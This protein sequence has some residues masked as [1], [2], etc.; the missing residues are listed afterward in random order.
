MSYR[1]SFLLF[2]ISSSCLLHAQTSISGI[3]NNYAQVTAIDTC[4]QRISVD[5]TAS[6]G[7][8]DTLLLIQM[9]GADIITDNTSGFGSISNMNNAG[10]FEKVIVQ[11]VQGNDLILT[12][13]I[14]NNYD[15]DGRVQ[16]VN[17]PYYE[18]AVVVDVL[19]AKEWDGITG[20]ILA[21]SAETLVLEADIDVSGVGFR[22]GTQEL[23]YDGDCVWF[24]NYTNF[25]YDEQSIRAG[26]KGEGI[27]I[28]ENIFARG[29][30]AYTNG[31]G[32]G[33]D[34]N[35]GGG[36]GSHVTAGGQG[37]IN[38]NP[39]FFGCNGDHPGLGGWALGLDTSRL[40]LG[41]GGGAGHINN[42]SSVQKSDGGGIVLLDVGWLSANGNRIKANGDNADT[43]NGDGANGGGAGGTIMIRATAQDESTLFLEAKGGN[44][45]NANN[46]NSDQCHGPGGGGAG[47]LLLLS[48]ELLFSSNMSGGE[49]GLS[50]NSSSC[51]TG[52]NGA[53]EGSDGQIAII[54]TIPEREHPIMTPQIEVPN[55][56][57]DACTEDPA[58][59]IAHVE[60]GVFDLQWQLDSGNGFEN[61]QDGM[62]FQGVNTDSLLVL[63]PTVDHSY[64]LQVETDCDIFFSIP[65]SIALINSPV[66]SFDYNIDGLNTNFTNTS[67]NA[68]TFTWL[69]DSEGTSIEAN[70]TFEFPLAGFYEVTLIAENE[71]NSDTIVQQLQIGAPPVPV[72]GVEGLTSGCVPLQ[73]QFN[74]LSQGTYDSVEWTF[75]GG[76]PATSVEEQPVVIYEEAGIYNVQLS[77]FSDFPTAAI[78]ESQLIEVFPQPVASFTYIIDGLTV[79][80]VNISSD[81]DSYFWDFGDGNS[82]DEVNPIHTYP[83][84]GNYVVTLNAANANC[85]AAFDFNVFIQPN[86]TSET[87]TNQAINLFPNPTNGRICIETDWQ[88]TQYQLFNGVG[89]IQGQGTRVENCLN[90]EQLPSGT[91]WLQ[92]SDGAE[93]VHLPVVI[94]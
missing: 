66:A 14:L 29:K 22:G 25:F 73:V 31:G 53:T 74:N 13:A 71:C 63:S 87:S 57:V 38:D 1:W 55:A 90:L 65:I 42:S 3:I 41:G 5:Q 12:N 19:Q 92:L 21:L 64:R 46:G 8:M 82:S 15:L 47:G 75:P 2:A 62:L 91:Y 35:A 79:S 40:F 11:E 72:I 89:A 58:I 32:G 23:D 76:Q 88:W 54:N 86:S 45:G 83:E 68:N 94:H 33:N 4:E 6:F 61:I 24:V 20:G 7:P 17:I 30:G 34:H 43:T 49:P 9:Q 52:T 16:I 59:L 81:S 56:I 78:T 51:G 69:F 28:A 44:G 27:G 48:P 70:P 80:F 36:G 67:T 60:G 39:T 50:I 77:V 37:G 84:A 18:L 26:F 10:R 85:T 93:E